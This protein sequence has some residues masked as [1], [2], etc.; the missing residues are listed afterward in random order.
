M[1][2]MR[3][4]FFVKIVN[5]KINVAEDNSKIGSRKRKEYVLSRNI[6]KRKTEGS[7][8][9]IPLSTKLEYKDIG[10]KTPLFLHSI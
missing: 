6:M 1:E 8:C 2:T 10:G 9:I 7:M 4:K 5:N 3:T